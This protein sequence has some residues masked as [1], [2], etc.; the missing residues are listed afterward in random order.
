MLS[1]HA[2]RTERWFRSMSDSKH[3][4]E[5]G[6]IIDPTLLANIQAAC[7]RRAAELEAATSAELRLSSELCYTGPVIRQEPEI[8]AA[9]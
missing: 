7:R 1:T 9:R 2:L 8:T 5:S 6:L 3:E 4:N